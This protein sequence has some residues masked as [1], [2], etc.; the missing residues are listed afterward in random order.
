MTVYRERERG[1]KCEE[2]TERIQVEIKR[3][4]AEEENPQKITLS[5]PILINPR[6]E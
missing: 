4:D 6:Q 5:T 1:D 2:W 3:D